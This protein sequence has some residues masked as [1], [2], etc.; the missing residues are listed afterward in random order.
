MADTPTTTGLLI[1]MARLER[2]WSQQELGSRARL[3]IST[4]HAV[5]TGADIRIGTLHRLARA[6]DVPAGDLI[7]ESQQAAAAS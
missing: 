2:G 5:E 4:V 1:R 3:S 6:L 7:G